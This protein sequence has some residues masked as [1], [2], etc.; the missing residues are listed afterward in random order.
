MLTLIVAVTPGTSTAR[1]ATPPAAADCCCEPV[2]LGPDEET[3][4][5]ATIT[6]GDPADGAAECNPEP[7]CDDKGDK[8]SW[9]QVLTIETGGSS[10]VVTIDFWECENNQGQ[11]QNCTQ[12]TGGL[13]IP[14]PANSTRTPTLRP[15]AACNSITQ[16]RIEC[17]G[18]SG[19]TIGYLCE[20]CAVGPCD[21]D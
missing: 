4:D 16:A 5:C 11:P 14:I 21:Q 18:N 6:Y 15:N 1:A 17:N 19:P 3:C 2:Y 13:G 7:E 10:C 20:P 12:G 8:C 9:T